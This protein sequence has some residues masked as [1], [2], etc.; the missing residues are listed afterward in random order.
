MTTFLIVL[1]AVLVILVM[2]G[3]ALTFSW[4]C[5]QVAGRTVGWALDAAAPCE[6][7]STLTPQRIAELDA[8]QERTRRTVARAERR[9]QGIEQL[10]AWE[11]ASR[12]T[13]SLAQAR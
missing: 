8:L 3:A 13:R 11:L 5:A 4:F 7:A 12:R 6:C 1:L 9:A 10:R 2:L